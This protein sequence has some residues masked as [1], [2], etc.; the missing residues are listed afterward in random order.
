MGVGWAGLGCAGRVGCG[1]WGGLGPSRPEMAIPQ[2]N[3]P[4]ADGI[5]HN[6]YLPVRREIVHLLFVGMPFA[7]QVVKHPEF[8]RR[9][10]CLDRVETSH[11]CHK[12]VELDAG[13]AFARHLMFS[14]NCLQKFASENVSG[15]S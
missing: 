13:I 6:Y 9:R 15:P 10:V 5:L 14:L 2:V 1:G 7:F 12:R 4:A 3:F 8:I 11:S